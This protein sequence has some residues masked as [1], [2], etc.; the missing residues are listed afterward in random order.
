[1]C[2]AGNNRP[3]AAN[4]D[5]RDGDHDRHGDACDDTPEPCD[6]QG[7][8][9]DGD[10]ICDPRDNC[11]D[12]PNVTPLDRDFY[13]IGYACDPSLPASSASSFLN[14]RRVSRWGSSGLIVLFTG[15]SASLDQDVLWIIDNLTA[16]LPTR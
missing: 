12:V 13:Q 10:G 5:Q 7:G 3:A 9:D 2:Q 14:V 6:A 1:M 8:D 15:S 11:A 4:P 16:A